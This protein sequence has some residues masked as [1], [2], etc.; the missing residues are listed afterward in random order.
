MIGGNVPL[1]ISQEGDEFCREI[2]N[3]ETEAR[4]NE[5]SELKDIYKRYDVYVNFIYNSDSIHCWIKYLTTR[6]YTNE[7]HELKYPEYLANRTS[8]E[9]QYRLI[10][11]LFNETPKTTLWDIP[12][13]Q[14]SDRPTYAKFI[15]F[16][17][18]FA[19]MRVSTINAKMVES[20]EFWIGAVNQ[21][22]TI[23]FQS[24]D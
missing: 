3:K 6:L 16:E 8:S 24:I 7:K 23:E 12:E 9:H 4:F 10:V 20:D 22:K 1:K 17:N 13:I 14:E 5:R 21:K 19:G 2:F 11:N 18:Y 15:A